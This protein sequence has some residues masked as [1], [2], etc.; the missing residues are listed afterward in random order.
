MTRLQTRSIA[1]PRA[2]P[3]SALDMSVAKKDAKKKWD[4]K[5]KEKDRV[6]RVRK[7]SR[8]L[9]D[10]INAEQKH[11]GD[12]RRANVQRKLENERKNMVVQKIK[13]DKAIRKLSPKHRRSA[14]IYMLHEL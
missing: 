10:E 12:A 7:L 8:Q 6:K 4:K 11:A 3:T 2:K 13:N 9:E 14:R 5:M 1:K